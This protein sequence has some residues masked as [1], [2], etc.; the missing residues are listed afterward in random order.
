[1]KWIVFFVP[2]VVAIDLYIWSVIAGLLTE[3]SDTAVLLGVLCISLVI[4]KHYFL[5]KYIKSK[6]K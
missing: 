4:A 3:S 6:F 5:F 2:V 1:M